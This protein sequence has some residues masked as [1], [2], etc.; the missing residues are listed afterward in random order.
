[1]TK[2]SEMKKSAFIYFMTNMA[3]TTLY[4]GVTNDLIRRVAEHK[5]KI[6]KGFTEKYNCA[7]LVYFEQ[8]DSITDAIER[9]KQLKNFKRQWKN[10]L[11]EEMNPEWRDLSTEIGV[12]NDLVEEIAGQARNK[13]SQGALRL[14]P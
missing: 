6:H 1:M 12:T 5:A 3:N 8:T 13:V 14:N 10:E 7:K 2:G 9:E 4:V 11:I